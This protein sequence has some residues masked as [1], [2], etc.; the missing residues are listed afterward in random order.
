MKSETVEQIRVEDIIP[1]RFQP[2][3]T[4]NEKELKELADSIKVH[5]VIQP[6]VLRKIGNKYEIIAGERRY[7]ASCIAGLKNVPAIVRDLSDNESAEIALIENLQRKN[8]TSIEE[9]QSFKN[10]LNRGYTTQDKLAEALGVTQSTISNK[11]RL[12]NLC[13]EVQNALLNNKISERHARSLLTLSD[14]DEQ[15]VILERIIKERLTVKQLD[16][17]LKKLKNPQVDTPSNEV[18]KP[19][20][21]ENNEPTKKIEENIKGDDIMEEN[22]PNNNYFGFQV[23]NESELSTNNVQEETTTNNENVEKSPEQI[24]FNPF[25]NN[26]NKFFTYNFENEETN[27]LEPSQPEEITSNEEPALEENTNEPS[28]NF[29]LFDIFGDEI[30]P[31]EKQESDEI[32]A[33]K[34][35]SLGDQINKIRDA[36]RSI[37]DEDFHIEMEEY[38]LEDIY[39]INIKIKKQKEGE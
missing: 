16:N 34:R 3:L 14:P 10:L 32:D 21:N 31:E 36:V 2:R 11:L 38:D 18:V 22:K 7:K 23:N 24:G 13:D 35:A 9:A 4:F 33:P 37:E 26:G 19:V 5:G 8:L 39:Q 29:E 6:L 27:N 28:E 1:N 17:E 20:N 12:L 25:S 15:K 30:K